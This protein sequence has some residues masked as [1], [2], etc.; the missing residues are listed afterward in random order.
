MAYSLLTMTEMNGRITLPIAKTE[1]AEAPLRWEEMSKQE[2]RLWVQ[3]EQEIETNMVS[4]KIMGEA[5]QRSK[6]G[7]QVEEIYVQL[8]YRQLWRQLAAQQRKLAVRETRR[9]KIVEWQ[10]STEQSTSENRPSLGRALV[11]GA[12]AIL[13]VTGLGVAAYAMVGFLTPQ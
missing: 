10:E 7:E 2:Q 3:A 5:R 4:A 6:N 8:R 11:M 13:A 12:I 1:P 9:A